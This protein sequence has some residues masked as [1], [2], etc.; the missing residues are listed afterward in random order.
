MRSGRESPGAGPISIGGGK[1][2]TARGVATLG[3]GWGVLVF[4]AGTGA[5]EDSVV[6]GTTT[7]DAAGAT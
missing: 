6:L 3:R 5:R 2:G 7:V 1:G 4:C